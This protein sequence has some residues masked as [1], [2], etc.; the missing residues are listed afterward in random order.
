MT[1]V[2][3]PSWRDGVHA[4]ALTV[5]VPY[6]LHSFRIMS[7]FSYWWLWHIFVLTSYHILSTDYVRGRIVYLCIFPLFL[8]VGFCILSLCIYAIFYSFFFYP[9]LTTFPTRSLVDGGPIFRLS[10]CFC[11]MIMSQILLNRDPC[12]DFVNKYAS[13]FSVLQY[14]INVLMIPTLSLA[15]K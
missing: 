4:C 14:S 15:K 9:T 1:S 6:P 2:C 3:A 11:P 12:R 5:L 7:S 13:M 8:Y 10:I